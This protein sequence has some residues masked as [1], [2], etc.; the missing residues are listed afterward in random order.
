MSPLVKKAITALALKEGIER[1]AEAR[2]PKKR[3][4]VLVRIAKM[5]ALGGA[6]YGAFQAYKSG[7]LK[8]LTDKLSGGSSYEGYEGSVTVQR[9]SDTQNGGSSNQT[10]GSSSVDETQPV[11]S[12]TV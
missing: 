7:M 3:K 9:P 5:G 10:E 2:R 4:N 11:G 12:P 8:P 6:A 1:I